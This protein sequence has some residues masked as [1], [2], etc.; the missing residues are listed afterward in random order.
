MAKSYEGKPYIYK[1]MKKEETPEEQKA[2]EERK[3][4]APVD[5]EEQ[6][7]DF[8]VLAKLVLEVKALA[9]KIKKDLQ[10]ADFE[11]D[12]DD[13]FHIDFIHASA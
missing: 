13:N 7:N 11:K 2:R 1:K 6:A 10:A 5:A 4:P 9:E 12:D 8:E 3:E